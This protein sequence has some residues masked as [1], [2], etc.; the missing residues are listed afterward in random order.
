MV[1]GASGGDLRQLALAAGPGLGDARL[2]QEPVAVQF[3]T[4]F[5]V[6][7]A[8]LLSGVAEGGVRVAVRFLGGCD[9]L[10]ERGDVR[11]ERGTGVG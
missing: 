5:E 11:V 7:V 1:G 9:G 10:G 4:P 6:A 8:R 3:V 2:D